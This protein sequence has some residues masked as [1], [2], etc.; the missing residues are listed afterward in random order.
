MNI[1]INDIED[2]DLR[3]KVIKYFKTSK[4]GKLDD[5]EKDGKVKECM[6]LCDYLYESFK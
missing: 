1:N 5:E 2:E 6:D 3:K 4:K